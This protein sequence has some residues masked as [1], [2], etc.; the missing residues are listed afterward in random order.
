MAESLNNSEEEIEEI[1]EIEEE[2]NDNEKEPLL[3]YTKE[4]WDQIESMD[5]FLIEAQD[6]TTE[7]EIFPR[8]NKAYLTKNGIMRLANNMNLDIDEIVEEQTDR[9]TYKV[10]ARAVNPQ[11]KHRYGAHEE[12]MNQ[13]HA[14]SKAYGK[15]QRNALREL[16][17]GHKNADAAIKHFIQ[18]NTS[19]Q[20]Y[21]QPPAQQ[22]APPQAEATTETDPTLEAR[23]K[24]YEAIKALLPDF[25]SKHQITEPMLWE[26]VKVRYGRSESIYFTKE[27]WEDLEEQIHM[28]P[29]PDWLTTPVP[30]ETQKAA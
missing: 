8:S 24:T 4:E 28:D 10:R 21:Q 6:F 25:E 2:F 9:K 7:V 16:I 30:S 29:I 18:S 20:N 22:Q 11:G 5:D 3:R 12:P 14:Y 23:A 17:A 15:A 26:R 1:E 13:P 27:D 19:N